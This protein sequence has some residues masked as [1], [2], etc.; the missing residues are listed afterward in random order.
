MRPRKEGL[1]TIQLLLDVRGRRR[2]SEVPLRLTVKALNVSH[3][4]SRGLL[5]A[6]LFFRI[7]EIYS[8]RLQGTDPNALI[9]SRVARSPASDVLC[10]CAAV[11]ERLTKQIAVAI[12][13]ALHPTG[14]GVVIE[15]TYVFVRCVFYSPFSFLHAGGC[16]PPQSHVHG[17]ARRSEDEQ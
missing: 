10:V 12:T 17:D 16:A 9:R 3:S 8:R 6:S 7:V 13:E 2:T 15:A 11:Q 5:T 14:V 4:H 1:I